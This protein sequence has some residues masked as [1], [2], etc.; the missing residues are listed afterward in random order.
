[1]YENFGKN[2]Y[3]DSSEEFSEET[4]LKNGKDNRIRIVCSMYCCNFVSFLHIVSLRIYSSLLLFVIYSNDIETTLAHEAKIMDCVNNCNVCTSFV[5]ISA[6]KLQ[7][8][9]FRDYY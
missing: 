4:C 9:N 8:A 2:V 5:A 6:E 7:K 1:M 3:N